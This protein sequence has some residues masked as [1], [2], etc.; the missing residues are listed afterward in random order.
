MLLPSHQ[1]I[2]AVTHGSDYDNQQLPIAED[3]LILQITV[4]RDKYVELT[5][6]RAEQI[7]VA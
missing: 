2:E 1:I 6:D 7:A 3:L 5:F 4:D